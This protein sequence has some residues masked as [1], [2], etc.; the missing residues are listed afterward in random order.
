MEYNHGMH[1]RK[2][3]RL[4]HY[5]YAEMGAYFVTICTHDRR[6]LFGEVVDKQM[7]LNEAGQIVEE[8]WHGIPC[9]FLHAA[10]Y[11]FIVM[12]N[13]IHGI[14]AIANGRGTACRAPTVEQ[15]GRPVSGS[16]PTVLR[17]FKSAVTK[18]INA[19]RGSHGMPVWQR[20]R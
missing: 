7:I 11:E 16:I 10:L 17:S 4:K 3:M 12:P 14:V 13:H 6:C 19:L 1:Y 15:F 18:R 5:D 20:N 9:H 2:S 8:C